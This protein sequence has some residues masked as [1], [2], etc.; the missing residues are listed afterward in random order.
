M[1]PD[2]VR[3]I[4]ML[5]LPD[6]SIRQEAIPKILRP[7]IAA[8]EN[9]FTSPL[10]IKT[11]FRLIRRPYVVRRWASIA[12]ANSEAVTD[13]LV[14]ILLGP[15]QDRGSAQAFYATLKAM[16]DSQFDPP[17]KTILPN[18]N[19]PILLIWGQQD[20]M[21]PPA[22]APQFAAYNPNVQ[23]LTLDN[24]GHFAH[25]EC[26]EEVNQGILTWMDSFLTPADE[27][28]VFPHSPI[29]Q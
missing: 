28:V 8:I 11:I 21:I 14:D 12:Y 19:I 1:H 25:D 20:R 9:L 7:A 22:F 5:S 17:A 15:A 29:S 3:G 10:L 2:M 24:A 16:L 6:L 13:E 26:P 18:L 27:S 23:L 4:V